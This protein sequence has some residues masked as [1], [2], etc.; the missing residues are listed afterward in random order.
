MRRRV[1]AVVGAVAGAVL[2]SGC[3]AEDLPLAAVTVDADGTPRVLMRPCDDDSYEAPAL[4]GWA[5]AYEDE[6]SDDETDTTLWA[7]D[8]EWSG[9]RE[10]PLFSPPGAWKAEV[11]GERRL[12]SGHAYRFVFYGQTDDYANGAVAFT[13]E[14]LGRLA[15][16]QVWAD[17][18]A[19]SVAEF[20]ELASDSC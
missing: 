10:F 17:Y 19:M 7:A 11:R 6:P 8:G 18:R 3:S 9:D 14:D 1:L 13:T 5:G 2:L 20:E 12:R 4:S 16:G 15:S